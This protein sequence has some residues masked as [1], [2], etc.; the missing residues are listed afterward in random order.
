MLIYP[1][2]FNNQFI[3]EYETENQSARLAIYNLM[4]VKVAEQNISSTKTVVDLSGISNEI[5]F[6]IIQDGN[7]KLHH[8]IV[9]Q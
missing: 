2:P 6:V 5:Y 3:V 8:K 9:K 1:N 4:G 7:N